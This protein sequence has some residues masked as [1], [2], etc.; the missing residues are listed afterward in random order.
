MDLLCPCQQ[1]LVQRESWPWQVLQGDVSNF[2]GGWYLSVPWLTNL[3][4]NLKSWDLPLSVHMNPTWVCLQMLERQKMFPIYPT[5]HWLRA[6]PAYSFHLQKFI[7][8]SASTN[9]VKT[10]MRKAQKEIERPKCPSIFILLYNYIPN[11]QCPFTW[12]SLSMDF[13]LENE[14]GLH[15]H[16][17]WLSL[18]SPSSAGWSWSQHLR[19]WPLITSGWDRHN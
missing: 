16:W 19:M 15:L 11:T 10:R 3:C 13:L 9:A 12:C 14:S 17:L 4:Y 5:K 6:Y 8:W 2:L 18:G 7:E 1:V